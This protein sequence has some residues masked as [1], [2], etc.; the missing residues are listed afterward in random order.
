MGIMGC[1][2]N[3][4]TGGS[5]KLFT[6]AWRNTSQQFTIPTDQRWI[7]EPYVNEMGVELGLIV[8]G[9]TPAHENFC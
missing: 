7:I 2:L 8:L 1:Y 3:G 9:F 6:P 4:V 5:E